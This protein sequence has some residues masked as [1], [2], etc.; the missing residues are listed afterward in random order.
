MIRKIANRLKWLFPNG[1]RS[2]SQCGE[3]VIMS[4]LCDSLG[5]ATPTYLDI[6]A[7]HPKYLSNTYLFYKRGSRGVSIEPDPS[8][9]AAMRRV[10]PRD[11][12][13]NVG[14]GT[15]EGTARFYV[16][17]VPTLNTFSEKEARR[18]EADNGH[19]IARVIDIELYDVERV[20]REHFASAPPDI[21]SIDVEGLD[22]EILKSMPFASKRPKIL[23]AETLTFNSDG[24]GEKIDEIGDF[25]RSVG[26]VLYADTYVNSIFVEGD[27]WRSR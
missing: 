9:I 3:D 18:L 8:L 5:I 10:R 1:I 15:S 6:G 11:T 22:L 20:Y 21:V 26:Y 14:I 25:M 2:Y 27:L 4:F 7:H 12:N 16:M 19:R 17:S 24:K 23:C 13:L